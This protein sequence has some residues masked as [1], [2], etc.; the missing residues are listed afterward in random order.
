MSDIEVNTEVLD[1]MSVDT[2][3]LPTGLPSTLPSMTVM[4]GHLMGTL[5]Q[6][7]QVSATGKTFYDHAGNVQWVKGLIDD[8]TYIEL[9]GSTST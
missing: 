2:F 6:R 7:I 3:A 9:L 1:V 5:L 8:S 4:M